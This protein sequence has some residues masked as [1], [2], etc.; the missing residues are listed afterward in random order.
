MPTAARFE[1]QSLD[2]EFV[3]RRTTLDHRCDL[4][5][6]TLDDGALQDRC[7]FR[8]G[9]AA[10]DAID[11][12][13]CGDEFC[14]KVTEHIA[15]HDDEPAMSAETI[16]ISQTK[17]L[18]RDDSFEHIEVERSQ[19]AV[20]REASAEHSRHGSRQRFANASC[21]CVPALRPSTWRR[22]RSL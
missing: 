9:L 14:G 12:V 8:P 4:V 7:P 1:F 5:D 22:S 6:E 17:D 10:F 21:C 19:N 2:V 15:Q 13:Q 18:H 3:N 20:V 11:L 16:G